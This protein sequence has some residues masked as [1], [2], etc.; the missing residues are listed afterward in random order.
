MF[1]STPAACA[2]VAVGLYKAYKH[3]EHSQQTTQED[4][5]AEEDPYFVALE[6]EDTGDSQAEE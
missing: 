1:K 6:E 3:W 2:L 4:D 5:A